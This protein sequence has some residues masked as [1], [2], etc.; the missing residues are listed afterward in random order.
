ME[1]HNR[2]ILED[3]CHGGN[4]FLYK[5]PSTTS[6]TTTLNAKPLFLTLASKTQSSI[7]T[8]TTPEWSTTSITRENPS[9]ER[10][11]EI[12]NARSCLLNFLNSVDILR[13]IGYWTTTSYPP[14]ITTTTASPSRTLTSGQ[15]FVRQTTA[16][17]DLTTEILTVNS[18]KSMT[19][20]ITEDIAKITTDNTAENVTEKLTEIVIETAI[21][22]P[23]ILSANN[24][25]SVTTV[26]MTQGEPV[27]AQRVDE[28]ILTAAPDFVQSFKDKNC[29]THF[30]HSTIFLLLIFA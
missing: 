19:E 16:T 18:T 4:I 17:I 27:T 7:Q 14:S 24:S 9:K 12:Q 28:T 5:N 25:M 21:D 11:K 26:K 13:T 22:R 8:I 3:E 23:T 15:S 1:T 30:A 6:M 2:K 20:G 29:S 10:M